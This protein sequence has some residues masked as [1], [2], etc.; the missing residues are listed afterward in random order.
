MLRPLIKRR[1]SNLERSRERGITIALVALAIFSIIAMAG[2][3]ID[4]GTL[5]QANS[6]A[7]RAADSAA[8]A[9]AKVLSLSGMT[10]DPNNI[11]GQWT[12]ACTAAS[13]VAQ[14]V[15]SQNTV[16]GNAPSAVTVTFLPGGGT[17]CAG[18]TGSFG[19]NPMVSVQV[20]QASLPTYFA[21]IWGRTGSSVTATATAEAFN[22]SGSAAYSSSTKVVP[23]Q[24]RCVKPMIVPN[25]DPGNPGP[26][27]VSLA[28]GTIT[29]GGIQT[30]GGGTTGIVGESFNL[31]P[32]CSATASTC[33]PLPSS[34]S[35]PQANVTGSAG[36]PAPPKPNLQYLPGQVLGT[37]VAVPSCATA[38][39]YQQ[40]LAGC[41]QST[42]YQCG[43]Q[44]ASATNIS[45]VNLNENPYTT[46][47]A[48][49]ALQCLTDP[50]GG[51]ADRLDTSMF[52][53]EMKAGAGNALGVSGVITS[54]N[55][56]ITIPIY[57]NTQPW[58]PNGSN[59]APVTIIGFLQ[60]FIN[61]VNASG[62]AN[63]TVLNVAGC[64]NGSA[65]TDPFVTGTSPV[66]VRLIT[67]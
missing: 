17:D 7:Q 33:N 51:G 61:S 39:P 25:L 49:T 27:F 56:V 16:G 48:N 28:G 30:N 32:D 31:F 44:S 18:A 22:P 8:L 37:P 20:T 62:V 34:P 35:P 10:G 46:T 3:S 67:P 54:S 42:P 47:D 38:N 45:Y 2:L 40:A 4:V 63:V 6:E 24:P 52:P 21:R 26:T 11:S 59:Q 53:Y 12:N 5:Y 50:T 64:G 58:V 60:V 57:D 15:A 9:A 41:D 66:P 55:S 36:A 19:V 14:A 29:T 23:V 65:S 43:V 13:Q 1:R